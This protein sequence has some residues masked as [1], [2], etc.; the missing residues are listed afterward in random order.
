MV[1]DEEKRRIIDGSVDQFIDK[2]T[3]EILGAAVPAYI[4]GNLQTQTYEKIKPSFAVAQDSARNWFSD[5]RTGLE[6]KGGGIIDGEF[7]PWLKEWDTELREKLTEVID[8]SIDE[9]WS[10]D[11]TSDSI[12]EI[13]GVEASRGDRIARTE[14]A[15]A[16][17]YGR[18]DRIRQ[19]GYT[20][21][22]WKTAPDREDVEACDD[23]KALDRLVF[24]IDDFP[25]QPL[26]PNCRCTCSP[27]L[28]SLAFPGEKPPIKIP[29]P[30]IPQPPPPIP[31]L[32]QVPVPIA[33]SQVPNPTLPPK[34]YIE[35]LKTLVEKNNSTPEYTYNTRYRGAGKA[36]GKVIG[37]ERHL[38]GKNLPEQIRP[39]VM[40]KN[41]DGLTTIV[42]AFDEQLRAQGLPGVRGVV[43]KPSTRYAAA[44]GDGILWI[45]PDSLQYDS[46][47]LDT[48]LPSTSKWYRGSDT[49]L[50]PANAVYY[51]ETG[52]ARLIIMG[53]HES[54]H[55][56][57][58]FVG[59]TLPSSKHYLTGSF[60]LSIENTFGSMTAAERASMS[61]SGYSKNIYEVLAETKA[62]YYYR[63]EAC[64]PRAVA[65]LKQWGI[66]K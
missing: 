50:K 2:A 5:Y 27:V 30:P 45:D 20:M 43:I 40:R 54:L 41:L 44:T 58:Q 46:A 23:C 21:V 51:G 52:R 61:P 60:T 28:S 49:A 59:A 38:L 19:G 39:E 25:E 62:T 22:R 36:A 9:G 17:F 48:P 6:D 64:D 13:L 26:H 32:T 10:T 18:M 29:E 8:T 47:Q 16:M 15:R 56:D 3:G 33:P 11:E 1:S 12:Q 42:T 53:I 66:I 55:T 7:V 4:K 63:P 35:K 57:N 65:F 31:S 34:E 37:I 14:I 24:P